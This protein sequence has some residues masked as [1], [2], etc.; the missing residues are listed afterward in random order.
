MEGQRGVIA[1][2]VDAASDIRLASARGAIDAGRLQARRGSIELE[3]ERDV[4]VES[5]AAETGTIS[6]TSRRGSVRVGTLRADAVSLSAPGAVTAGSVNVASAVNL[7]GNTVNASINS[8]GPG[9]VGGS[10][11]GF[12][13]GMASDVQ[14]ALNSPFAFRLS[15][16]AASTG[17]ISISDGDLFV[18][19]LW[20]GNR[21]TVS[22]PFTRAL[23]D[24]ND[25]SIQPF[26]VQ[27]YSAGEPFA[28]GLTRNRVF[29]DAFVVARERTHEI[30]SPLG[31]NLSAAELGEREMSLLWSMDAP[32]DDLWLG[33]GW[34][35]RGFGAQSG[36]LVSF[37]GTPV[38]T[39]EACEA[40]SG[41]GSTLS[42]N[43]QCEEN[44]Q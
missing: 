41:Q 40:S 15:T 9:D 25:R 14:L 16:V 30:I 23:I 8:T 38:D 10:V 31:N 43:A 36:T 26:D 39:E 32:T 18:D 29:T 33:A 1:G 2:R 42:G 20:V 19:R 27:L 37:D 28:F 4:D 6:A 44:N 22:N 11:T 24:Q 21:M 13:G 5:G 7:A 34:W 12:G 17:N 3:A 35:S